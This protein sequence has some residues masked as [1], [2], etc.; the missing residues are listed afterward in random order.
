[1]L[2]T[3]LKENE[4]RYLKGRTLC[5]LATASREAEPHVTPVIYAMDG[6]EIGRAHV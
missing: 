3:V 5:R 4:I 2:L 1:M 6:E